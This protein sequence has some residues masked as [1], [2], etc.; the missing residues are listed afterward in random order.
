MLV[1]TVKKFGFFQRA[2]RELVYAFFLGSLPFFAC[3][4]SK[5][6]SD[7]VNAL[8]AAPILMSYYL[9][10]L[11][12]FGFVSIFILKV[13]FRLYHLIRKSREVHSFFVNIGG[14]LLTAFRAALGAMMGYLMV[15]SYRDVESMSVAGTSGVV[16]YAFMTLLVCVWLAWTDETLRNPHAISRYS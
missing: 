11:F 4:S 16:R 9:G 8:L 12:A 6:V 14:S 1:K 10:L 15:W 3:K 5:E 13:T 7:L 2:L